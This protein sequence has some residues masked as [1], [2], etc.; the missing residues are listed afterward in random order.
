MRDEAGTVKL[1]QPRRG[2]TRGAARSVQADVPKPSTANPSSQR[3]ERW[4]VET[5]H[6]DIATLHIPASL[7]ARRVFEIDV[8]LVVRAAIP[9]KTPPWLALT[10]E[11]DGAQQWSRRI[12]AS[13]PGASDS[14]DYH[15]R[16]EVMP[17]QALRVRALSKLGGA[18]RLAL[19][20]E[21]E[22]ALPS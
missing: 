22:Q 19:V 2:P 12:D 20:I 18:A 8:R 5:A 21:A 16:R 3:P 7:G 6:A 9:A 15:C 11:I 14:L 17:G 13:C 1:R 10:V 4:V